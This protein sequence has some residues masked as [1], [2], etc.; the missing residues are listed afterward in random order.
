MNKFA[1][2]LI[3]LIGSICTTAG[4]A[5]N[6][7]YPPSDYMMTPEAEITLARSAAPDKVSAHASVKVLTASG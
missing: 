6:S 1:F 4:W 3:S 2:T 7:A 5:Q